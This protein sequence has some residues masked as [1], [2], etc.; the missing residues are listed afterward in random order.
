LS[1]G[2]RI[3]TAPSDDVPVVERKERPMKRVTLVFLMV[4]MA[5]GAGLWIGVLRPHG[6]RSSPAPRALP[7]AG[8]LP[9]PRQAA[10]PSPSPFPATDL[11]DGRYYG[12]IKALHT[13]GAE[14]TLDLDVAQ[15]FAGAAAD[16]AA[17]EDGL[18]QPGEHVDDDSYVRNVSSRIRTLA[19]ASDVAVEAL[20]GGCCDNHPETFADFVARFER[21]PDD[22]GFGSFLSGWW[23]TIRD[24]GIVRIEE[25]YT[26]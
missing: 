18:I 12:F 7:S 21:G 26:P 1:T 2:D 25:Q 24:G 23:L 6:V 8:V 10:S 15:R 20:A 5:A 14:A 17:I 4:A 22:R 11:A 3:D 19:I 13:S 16:Q 9:S